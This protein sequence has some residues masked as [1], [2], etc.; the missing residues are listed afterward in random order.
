MT[1]MGIITGELPELL[2]AQQE[3]ELA[4]RIEAGL[5]AAHVLAEGL[6]CADATVAELRQLQEM[7]E[8]AFGDFVTANLKLA[9]RLAA[10]A[11][12]RSGVSAE[13]LFQDACLGLVEALLRFDHRR[14]MKFST[15]AFPWVRNAVACSQATRGGQL[16][17]SVHR[18]RQ[19]RR[20]RAEAAWLGSRLGHELTAAE[21]AEHLGRDSDWVRRALVA[22]QPFELDLDLDR[23][24]CST[25]P[26]G[27]AAVEPP[28]LDWWQG[29]GGL[30]ARVLR[31]RFGLDDG[32]PR[33]LQ[34][35]ARLLGTSVSSVRRVERQALEHA[36]QLARQDLEAA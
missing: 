17:T 26:D 36:R 8:Q 4:R 6:P 23:I 29:L 25:A 10:E 32:N 3:Q 16:P 12:Q 13:E 18:A 7:G 14:G 2:T 9:L 21:L 33:T 5:Y 22:D 28:A 24:A 35:T 15:Y 19:A 31:L 30:E 34:D 11:H 20:L 27:F 1:D